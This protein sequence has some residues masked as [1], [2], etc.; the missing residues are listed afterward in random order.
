MDESIPLIVAGIASVALTAMTGYFVMLP[1]LGAL[2][3][4]LWGLSS[5]Q[6]GSAAQPRLEA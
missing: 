2:R 1:G 5:H 3:G 4:R 6:L